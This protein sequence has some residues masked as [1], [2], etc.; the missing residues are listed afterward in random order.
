MVP[1]A[2]VV[3]LPSAGPPSGPNVTVVENSQL[4]PCGTQESFPDL[5][6]SDGNVLTN[7]AHSY[8][9]CS[10]KGTC[11]RSAGVCACFDGYSGSACQ[12]ASCPTNVNGICSGHGTCQTA[13]A[14]A[15]AESGNVYDL[16]DS[17][18]TLGC[19]C[20]PG[21]DGPDCSERECK[22]GADPLYSD[23]VATVRLPNVT[24]MAYTKYASPAATIQ[25]TYAI[26][27]TDNMGKPWQTVPLDYRAECADI[28][29]SGVTY[30]GVITALEGLPNNII[31]KGSVRC[32]KWD[33]L[34][35][36]EPGL[37]ANAWTEPFDRNIQV[38]TLISMQ[39]KFTVVFSQNIGALPPLKLN[40][41]LD[42]SRPTLYSDETVSTL[43]YFS[44]SD[45]FSGEYTD[46]VPDLCA[47]VNATLKLVPTQNYYVLEPYD[48][49]QTALL[50]ACLGGADG[51][52][53]NNVEV[54]NWDYGSIFNPHLIKLVETT[55]EIPSYIDTKVCHNV[56]NLSPMTHICDSTTGI[57]YS[58]Y[59]TTTT[60]TTA[61]TTTATCNNFNPPGFFAVLQYNGGEFQVFTRAG[62]DYGDVD[63]NG[64]LVAT[65]F[66]VFTTTGY[67]QRVSSSVDAYTLYGGDGSSIGNLNYPAT[68]LSSNTVRTVTNNNNRYS[69]Y[70][71]NV[72]CA[73]NPANTNGLLD[74]VNVGDMVMLFN[75]NQ[76]QS[77]LLANPVY[78][79]IYTLLK[80]SPALPTSDSQRPDD[81]N[82]LILDSPVN[83]VFTSFRDTSYTPHEPYDTAAGLF[84][85]YP[86]SN[87]GYT[88]A[89]PCSGRGICGQST[90]ICTCFAGYTYDNCGVINA[91]AV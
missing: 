3:G 83:S 28:V 17:E 49:S 69:G 63:Q 76:T 16:W 29:I 41:Y 26:I 7:T 60:Q 37:L 13:K 75:T 82:Q 25:G 42:G 77:T 84:K 43:D 14:I 48:A 1:P 73:T 68:E 65:S 5:T 72:D 91:L 27:F 10:N 15:S 61:S 50:K 24:F 33:S 81:L 62:Q 35:T 71:G 40:F 39:F 54:Y 2:E 79:Q 6:D 36:S 8:M 4:Y 12:Y 31:P 55:Q 45:G 90:G 86:P 74:C 20:D 38:E 66:Y 52:P 89:A 32:L 18:Q 85:F 88:Y 80:T 57:I 47:G 19:V 9:E 70:Y 53:A 44:F 21:Y 78:P 34:Y 64:N 59:P 22:Y 56:S 11:D 67:L 51:N 30:I 58:S 87:G 46:Y 23:G